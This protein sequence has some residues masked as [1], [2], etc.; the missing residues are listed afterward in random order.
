MTSSVVAHWSEND[1]IGILTELAA[2]Q[3]QLLVQQHNHLVDFHKEQ[4]LQKNRYSGWTVQRPDCVGVDANE[5]FILNESKLLPGL[6]G[7]HAAER[8]ESVF[9]QN[10]G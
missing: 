3:Q 9:Q 7:V 4:E 8:M 6:L 1:D 10:N 5:R 2:A